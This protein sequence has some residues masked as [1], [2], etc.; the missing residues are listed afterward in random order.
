MTD[1]APLPRERRHTLRFLEY[2][3]GL[4][5]VFLD[6]EVDMTA[7]REHRTA[8]RQRG[9]RYSWVTYLLH[10]A[11]RVLDEHPEANAALRGR[12]R[13]RVARY[14]S[15]DAKVAFD[16]RLGG[17]RVVLSGIVPGIHTATLDDIQRQV[18]R[19]RDGDPAVIPEFSGTRVLQRLP[20]PLGAA[21]FRAATGPLGGRPRRMGTLAVSSLGHSSV[22]GFQSV[23]GTTVTLGMGR[24]TERPVARDGQLAIAPVTRLNLAF[25]HRVID[26]AEAADVLTDLRRRLESF[27]TAPTGQRAPAAREAVA[28]GSDG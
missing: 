25:D 9:R 12:L 16:K 18:D 28:E 14:G 10:V 15:V 11:G 6:T 7:V 24:V 1:T 26:G 17:H 23:G 20:W 21:A 5:P 22:D 8:A 27:T 2:A 4:S 13:P 19:Y 3:R